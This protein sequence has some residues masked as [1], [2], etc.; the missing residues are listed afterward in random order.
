MSDT[1][2]LYRTSVSPPYVQIPPA[3]VMNEQLRTPRKES[4][5]ASAQPSHGAAGHGDWIR[6]SRDFIEKHISYGAPTAQMIETLSRDNTSTN[7]KVSPK[8]RDKGKG[9][10]RDLPSPPNLRSKG[11]EEAD[12][13]AEADHIEMVRD[14]ED[15]DFGF[16]GPS[17][18]P[19]KRRAAAQVGPSP[20]RKRAKQPRSRHIPY[21]SCKGQSRKD[22]DRYVARIRENLPGSVE[23]W[24]PKSAWPTKSIKI[25]KGKEE[26]RPIEDPK[27]WNGRLLEEL[28]Y[29]AG[30]MKNKPADVHKALQDAVARKDRMSG[31]RLELLED[32]VQYAIKKCERAQPSTVSAAQTNAIT[33]GPEETRTA[34]IPNEMV[35][36]MNFQ[37]ERPLPPPRSPTF[38]GDDYVVKQESRPN[39]ASSS[40]R[41]QSHGGWEGYDEGRERLEELKLVEEVKKAEAEAKA[42]KLA[43]FVQQRRHRELARQH[44]HNQGDAILLRSSEG[45]E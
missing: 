40:R 16:D 32:D 41:V 22:R 28:A 27:D 2:S 5:T 12:F 11:R 9:R 42:A 45:E 10:A 24:M 35:A 6:K 26:R 38:A 29:L 36:D 4:K 43:R 39:L 23:Q 44:G 13:Q 20:P 18:T 1:D 25:A 14:Q 31:V 33:G 30:V 8:G 17:I 34:D 19:R 7:Q 3:V 21:E 37:A 15:P